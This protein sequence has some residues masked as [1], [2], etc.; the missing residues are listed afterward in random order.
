MNPVAPLSMTGKTVKE[1]ES[2]RI[3]GPLSKQEFLAHL[4]DRGQITR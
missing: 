3:S 2:G 1:Y 4:R